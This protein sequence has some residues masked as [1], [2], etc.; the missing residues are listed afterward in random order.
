MTV[1]ESRVSDL[2]VTSKLVRNTR[3]TTTVW[4]IGYYRKDVD[5]LMTAVAAI[6]HH[7]ETGGS[8][9][10][11]QGQ[12]M[13]QVKAMREHFLETTW[14]VRGYRRDEVDRLRA[15]AQAMLE[16]W[17]SGRASA[18]PDLRETLDAQTMTIPLPQAI[19][20]TGDE[21]LEVVFTTT[22]FREGYDQREVDDFLDVA[23]ETLR[24]YERGGSRASLPDNAV[25]AD[26]VKQV[27]FSIG[28]VRRGYDEREVD[29]ALV[30]LHSAL[31]VHE[32]R[33]EVRQ[34]RGGG[35]T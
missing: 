18:D 9:A 6:L 16:E 32:A 24:H 34:P 10:A 22:Q 28:S 14:L 17:E 5:E 19:P 11:A 30:K 20:I 8:V 31:R 25:S 26:G 33:G 13:L 21:L 7:Y 23:V 12:R 27:T 3:F 2:K 15:G 29:A 35:W 1:E 4:R